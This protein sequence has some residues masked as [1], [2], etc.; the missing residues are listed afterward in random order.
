VAYSF[1]PRFDENR[2]EMK[3]GQLCCSIRNKMTTLVLAIY[4]GN[5]VMLNQSGIFVNFDNQ[6]TSQHGGHFRNRGFSYSN[7]FICYL[8]GNT[9][10]IYP[11]F[12]SRKPGKEWTPRVPNMADEGKRWR[13]EYFYSQRQRTVQILRPN[14]VCFSTL[15]LNLSCLKNFVASTKIML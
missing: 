3:R 4:I 10:A 1:C 7:R 15:P 9:R 8:F 2:R 6:V 5:A 13:S 12:Y 14:Q 11:H